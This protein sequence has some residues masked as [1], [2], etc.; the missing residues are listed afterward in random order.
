MRG[1][2]SSHVSFAVA[3]TSTGKQLGEET[4]RFARPHSAHICGFAWLCWLL[5]G[6]ASLSGTSKRSAASS[7]TKSRRIGAVEPPSTARLLNTS[8]LRRSIVL[9]G[10]RRYSTGS[11]A[12]GP[13]LA[14]TCAGQ[15]SEEMCGSVDGGVLRTAQPRVAGGVASHAAF[16]GVSHIARCCMLH[17]EAVAPQAV[18]RH[19]A[20]GGP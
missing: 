14:Q 15:R 20:A 11:P 3:D 7:A 19:P 2:S 4:S 16:R 17:D 6:A 18:T 8:G 10:T 1:A 13:A 12:C 9:D 5:Q